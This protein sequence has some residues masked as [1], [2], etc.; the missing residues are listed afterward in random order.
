M[1]EWV[2]RACQGSLEKQQARRT[3]EG[4]ISGYRRAELGQSGALCIR[5]TTTQSDANTTRKELLAAMCSP[6]QLRLPIAMAVT[7]LQSLLLLF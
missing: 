4:W 3:E 6:S 2:R 7:A 1:Q 5:K